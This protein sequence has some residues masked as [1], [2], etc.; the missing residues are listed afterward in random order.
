MAHSSTPN[1][2][3]MVDTK[4]ILQGNEWVIFCMIWPLPDRPFRIETF[5]LRGC[6]ECGLIR[7]PTWIP[8][9]IAF[10]C[11]NPTCQCRGANTQPLSVIG[12]ISEGSSQL[13][14]PQLGSTKASLTGI[15]SQSTLLLLF[16][17]FMHI[18]IWVYFPEK[19]PF[20]RNCLLQSSMGFS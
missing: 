16:A 1:A 10:C 9:G 11:R 20:S 8:V 19:W 4:Y 17:P 12:A 2:K 13:Q 6:W 14:N 7:T 15:I 5:I 3:H 18:C